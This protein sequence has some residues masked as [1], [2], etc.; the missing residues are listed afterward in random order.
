VRIFRRNNIQPQGARFEHI[1]VIGLSDSDQTTAFVP[2]RSHV[3]K[4]ERNVNLIYISRRKKQ[5]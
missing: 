4:F 1:S 5:R 2:S 3:L